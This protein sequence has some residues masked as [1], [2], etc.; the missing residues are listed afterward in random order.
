MR[1]SRRVFWALILAVVVMLAESP[2]SLGQQGIEKAQQETGARSQETK[3]LDRKLAE[4]LKLYYDQEFDKALLI[5]E[6]IADKLETM[7]LMF[8]VGTSAA[9]VE[10]YEIAIENFQKMLSIDPNLHRVRLDL[11]DVL[12]KSGRY[13]EARQELERLK[14]AS[15]PKSLETN[16][17]KRLR[18]ARISERTKKIRWGVLFS[19]GYQYDDNLSSGP[20]RSEVDVLLGTLHLDEKQK[21]L[22]GYNWLTSLTSNARYDIG[23]AKGLVWNAELDFFYSKNQSYSEFN[24]MSVDVSTGPWMVGSRDILQLP[25]GYTHTRYGDA[26]LSKVFH[27][28]PNF[29]HFF[30]N[31]F[32]IQTSALLAVE[33]YI[34]SEYDE[35]DNTLLSLSLGPN[36]YFKQGRHIISGYVTLESRDG[37]LKR[38][39]SDAT[40]FT[41]SYFLKL[42]TDTGVF[43]RY[44]WRERQYRDN[45]LLYGDKRED[46]TNRISATVSRT[47]LE[48]F[49]ASFEWTYV[50][51]DSN[52]ELYEFEKT[53]YALNAGV[54]F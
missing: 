41:L 13:E 3:A 39:S 19:Q 25:V 4:A 52:A 33:D 29:E 53:T 45:P 43:F 38:T 6:E 27:F 48:R 30:N 42:P 11:A 15:P 54:I 26:D 37:D 22:D 28:D 50:E 14:A 2:T 34:P 21:K 20:D 9:K 12:L 40:S 23:K 16:I 24:F 47:F 1:K 44:R 36:F 7:D 51:N 35:Y 10:K 18:L 5:F 46:S 17:D 49:F 8:W 32:S 31:N